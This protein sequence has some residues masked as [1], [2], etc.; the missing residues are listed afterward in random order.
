MSLLNR[1]LFSAITE[2][3][4]DH[5]VSLLNERPGLQ[6][7]AEEACALCLSVSLLNRDLFSAI[8]RAGVTA[9]STELTRATVAQQLVRVLDGWG[10][11]WV[12]VS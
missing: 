7:L 11:V 3:T 8:V 1:D 4:L 6:E 9:S 5:P 10:S 12:T 2:L